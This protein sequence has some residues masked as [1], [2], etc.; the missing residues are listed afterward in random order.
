LLQPE[1]SEIEEV[2]IRAER[3]SKVIRGDT[4]NIMDYEIDGN[5]IV[6]VA[7][8]YR[9]QNDQRIYLTDN[10][11]NIIDALK[12]DHGGKEIK[13]PEIMVPQTLFL[14]KDFT[15]QVHFLNK[16]SAREVFHEKD[17]LSFGY[18]TQYSDFISRLLPVKCE[19][20]RWLVFQVSTISE[21]F[22]YFFGPGFQDGECIK[23]VYEI[24]FC[25]R[26]LQK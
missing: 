20:T 2:T 14:F 16:E 4:L 1:T 21:N 19:M 24:C 7:N 15:G 11:G 8:P 13:I 26:D 12:V 22:T 3:I 6:M 9:H 18:N 23:T 17:T 10:E 5:R 25:T